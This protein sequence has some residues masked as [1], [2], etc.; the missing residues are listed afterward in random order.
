MRGSRVHVFDKIVTGAAVAQLVE[1]L[2]RNETVGG[3]IPLCGTIIKS[4]LDDFFLFS[5]QKV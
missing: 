5:T 2:I 1:Y 3:S 4:S